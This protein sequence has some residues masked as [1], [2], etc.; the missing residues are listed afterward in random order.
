VSGYYDEAAV[1]L[2]F[3][4]LKPESSSDTKTSKGSSPSTKK[5][6]GNQGDGANGQNANLPTSASS[7]SPQQLTPLDT[8]KPG[9]FVMIFST[10]ADAVA[11]TIGNFA[12]SNA[13]AQAIG[14]LVGRSQKSAGKQNADKV[15]SLDASVAATSAEISAL[16]NQ[17]PT[18]AP[19][20]RPTIQAYLR[21]LS[22]IS[23]GLG[24]GQDF[25]SLEQAATWFNGARLSAQKE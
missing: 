20:A 23:R 24:T 22:C 10:N 19:A 2:L 11:D 15:A 25:Q 16:I 1:D 3:N 6:S 5:A 4:E 12:E 7:S 21:V 13:T 8:S 14:N 9:S 18:T 17:V